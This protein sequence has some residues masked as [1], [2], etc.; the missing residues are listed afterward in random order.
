MTGSVVT[1]SVFSWPGIGLLVV[2]A[3]R[4]RDF[5]VVQA[6]VIVFAG[7]FI[8]S[9]LLVDIL[10]AYLDPRI[11]LSV[12]DMTERRPDHAATV[13][14]TNAPLVRAALGRR[15]AMRKARRYPLV[16]LAILHV[17]PGDSRRA[18]RRRSRRTIRFKGSLSNRLTPPVWQEGG[19]I[20]HLLGTDKLGR[21]MP[22]PHHLRRARLA[23]GVAGR[24]LR[25]R[26]H[27]HQP[28]ADVGLLRRPGGRR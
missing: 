26:D 17:P 12:R 18:S 4:S 14:T 24:D 23:R 13:T 10:Y 28:G 20:E 16:P 25:R 15:R 22:E 11:R 21:D 7:I 5:Q 6:V 9:N 27:R 19:T 8:L 2:D 3:V 1:E